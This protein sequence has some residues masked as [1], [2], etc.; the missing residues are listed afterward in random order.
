MNLE[1][2]H[3][4]QEKEMS[5]WHASARMLFAYRHN[6]SLDPLPDN[7]EKNE[8]LSINWFID[9]AGSVGVKIIQE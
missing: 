6:A 7:Y 2:P 9:L 5:C 8:G 1:V 3:I 4:V